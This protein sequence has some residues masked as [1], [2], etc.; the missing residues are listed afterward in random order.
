MLYKTKDIKE[1]KKTVSILNEAGNDTENGR[2]AELLL[3][4]CFLWGILLSVKELGYSDVCMVAAMLTGTAVVLLQ[5]ITRNREKAAERIKTVLYIGG[6][7]CFAGGIRFIIQGFLYTADIFLQLWNLRFHTEFQQMQVSSKAGAGALLLWVLISLVLSSFLASQIRRKKFYGILLSTVAALAFGYVLGQSGMWI[8]TLLIFAGTLEL[9]VFYSAPLRKLVLKD[10]F[11]TAM[12]AVLVAAMIVATGGYHKISGIERWKQETADKID[13]IRYGEDSLPQG[14]LNKAQ[15]LLKGNEDTLKI[16][17]K[18]PQELYLRGFTGGTYNGSYWSTLD[19]SAYEGDYA[20]MLEWLLGKGLNPVKQ[21]SSYNKLTEEAAGKSSSGEQITVENKG[22]YRR[23]V[24][25]P[26]QAD[27]WTEQ[28]SKV[29]KD[30]NVLSSRFFGTSSYE[31]EVSDNIPSAD[32]VYLDS[33][34]EQPEVQEQTEYLN[35]ES[36]YHSF[37]KDNYLEVENELEPLLNEFFFQDENIDKEDFNQ[38]TTVIRQKLRMNLDYTED[39]TKVPAGEDY[40]KWFLSDE[41]SGN[42]VAFASAA[43]MAYREAGYPARYVEGYHLTSQEAESMKDGKKDHITMT[44]K[45]AHAWAEVY[46][47]GAGWLPVEVVPGFY[48]ETYSNQIVEGR[49][50]YKINSSAEDQGIGTEDQGSTG[51]GGE[52]GRKDQEQGKEIRHMVPEYL[53]L[54]LYLLLFIYLV[55]ELQRYIRIRIWKNKLKNKNTPEEK[56]DTHLEMAEGLMHLAGVQGDYSHPAE[57]WEQMQSRF[58]GIAKEE[59]DRTVEL[60]QKAR[61]GGIELKPYEYHTLECYR[62]K[63]CQGLYAG[64]GKA[65]KLILRYVWAVPVYKESE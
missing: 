1:N 23:Y 36:V 8:P 6:V 55:L 21:Y 18:N 3:N 62:I 10:I 7:A 65:G 39:P 26:A 27:S 35:A 40:I 19:L 47:S 46:I 52:S 14:N 11:C 17:M 32:T 12:V 33:W 56:L 5:Q 58:P 61:F 16:T 60:L 50:A 38:V 45:N 15:G 24:Y 49:P 57:L 20:G 37:V 48:V 41:K 28:G 31:F 54:A 42:A 64:K 13:R 22:A 4:L 25:L 29:R 34:L 44:T 59:Y 63:L 30:W 53:M 43:V 51:A 2:T 9:F